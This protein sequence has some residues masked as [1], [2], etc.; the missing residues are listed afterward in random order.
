M[1]RFPDG[2]WADGGWEEVEVF[3]IGPQHGKSHPNFWGLRSRERNVPAVIDENNTCWEMH[4]RHK[5]MK[6]N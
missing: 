4:A 1:G 5:L 6:G 3:E 2:G